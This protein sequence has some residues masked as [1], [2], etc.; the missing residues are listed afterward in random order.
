MAL[1]PGVRIGVYEIT[2]TL[3]A[4]GMG[5]VYRATDINLSRHVAIKVLPD[6]FANDPERL[7]RFEREA[8]TLAS[9]NHPNIAQIY[10]FEKADGIRALAMELVEGPTLADR[11]A[12]GPIPVDEALRIAKQ[13]AEALVA[14]HE[15]GVIHRDLKPANIKLRPDGTVKVLD[16]GLAKALEPP[17]STH[18][19]ATASP[20]I[21]SPAMMTGVGVLL[22]TAAYMSPEQARGKVVDKRSDIWAF[23]CVLYE[24][25]SGKRAFEGEEVSDTLAA[26]LRGDPDWAALPPTVPRSVALMVRRCLEKDPKRRLHDIADAQILTEEISNLEGR[27]PSDARLTSWSR[28]A[29]R[30]AVAI[31]LLFVGAAVALFV[32]RLMTRTAAGRVERFEIVTPPDAAFTVVAPGP[33]VVLSPDGFQV[34]YHVET[35]GPWRLALRKLDRLE[36]VVMPGTEAGLFPVFSPDGAQLAF[37]S[38]RR[39]MRVPV[40]GGPATL[41][42]ELTAEPVGLSWD[43]NDVIVFAERGNGVFRVATAGGKPERLAT[44]DTK[45]GELD[46][47]APQLLPGGET[48]L[49]T[50]IPV[51]GTS[52][53]ARIAARV[54]ATE[55]VTVL[56][57]GAGPARYAPTGY[58]VYN[59][60]GNLMAAPLDIETLS[61]GSSALVQ[62][63]VLAKSA[64]LDGAAVD[65]SVGSDGSMI[66]AP[67]RTDDLQRV[68]WVDREGTRLGPLTEQP[69]VYP[70]YP[71]L[72]PDGRRLAITIGPGNEGQIWIYDLTGASQPLKLTYE[73]HNTQPTWAP[74]G[75]HIVFAST[76]QGRPAEGTRTLTN[77]NLFRLPSDASSLDP[78]RL[79]TSPI[80][81]YLSRGHIARSYCS[82]KSELDLGS[83]GDFR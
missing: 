69:L 50:I 15:Q 13:I 68:I 73:G 25:L 71:R 78:E 67:G 41:I 51:E 56:V 7:A 82:G 5:E 44:P 10:G 17:S 38:R 63:G 46:Y 28:H 53:Q 77:R 65:F 33:N 57:E 9:L 60:A 54:L 62:Q 59:K 45:K 2:G 43:T 49:F 30:V 8:K 80:S 21:T 58:L 19:D 52:N 48:I 81:K 36:Q 12:Q 55:A 83:S 4:G 75:T 6:T 47:F 24:M 74:S 11:I 35:G 22:G 20:T 29:V 39:L 42:C 61:I 14:A 64:L 66:Y 70:R 40:S 18:V 31:T 32:T 37:V 76:A 1:T 72:S 34:A 79:T 23:G 16:F 3:G 26:V 27:P